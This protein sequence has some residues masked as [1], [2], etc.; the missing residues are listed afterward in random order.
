MTW[1][2]IP[3]QPDGRLI[4]APDCKP[5]RFRDGR[6]ITWFEDGDDERRENLYRLIAYPD[7]R[8]EWQQLVF[9]DDL[10]AI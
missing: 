1:Q 5:T 4:Q 9:P 10:E 3:A 8:S 7:G 6:T 2:T